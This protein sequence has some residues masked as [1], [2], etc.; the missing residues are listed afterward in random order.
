MEKIYG[1][2][3]RSK[4]SASL[5]AVPA[6]NYTDLMSQFMILRQSLN[7]LGYAAS[8]W[9]TECKKLRATSPSAEALVS[10]RALSKATTEALE[11]RVKWLDEKIK[12]LEE[13]KKLLTQKV[14]VLEKVGLEQDAFFKATA[15]LKEALKQEA[16]IKTIVTLQEA[17]ESYADRSEW[18]GHPWKLLFKQSSID[19]DGF[20]IAETAL[21]KVGDAI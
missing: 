14:Q 17:L 4:T 18:S 19:G 15:T 16:L 10:E 8:Y 1:K 12:L 3:E 6:D 21:A 9:E 7:T 2:E 20:V 11:E 13:D 5:C